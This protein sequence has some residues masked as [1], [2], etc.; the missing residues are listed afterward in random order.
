M[1]QKKNHSS[2]GLKFHTQSKLPA[3]LAADLEKILTSTFEFIW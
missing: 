1:K 2:S 3:K